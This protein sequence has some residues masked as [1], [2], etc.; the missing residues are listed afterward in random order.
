[1]HAKARKVCTSAHFLRTQKHAPREGSTSKGGGAER[2]PS[3]PVGQ[4]EKREKLVSQDGGSL[5]IS[6]RELTLGT[7]QTNVRTTVLQTALLLEHGV[8]GLGVGGEAPADGET[9]TS[10]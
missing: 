2:G 6:G 4:F 3:S 7:A 5:G 10:S 8:V 1:M 9:T